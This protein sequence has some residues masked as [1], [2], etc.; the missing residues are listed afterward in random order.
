MVLGADDALPTNQPLS[1]GGG[2]AGDW[3]KVDL[4]G[5]SQTVTPL[6]QQGDATGLAANEITNSNAARRAR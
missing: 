2:A 5:H 6:L 3:G 1:V 4:N